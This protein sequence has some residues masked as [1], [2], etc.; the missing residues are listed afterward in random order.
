MLSEI[1]ARQTTSFEDTQNEYIVKAIAYI[2]ENISQ[3]LTIEQ[4]AAHCNMS[5]SSLSHLFKREMRIPLHRF[6]L[7]KRLMKAHHKIA[8]G[9]AATIAAADCGF[10]DYSG[11]YKQFKKMFGYAPSKRE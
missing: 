3:K 1:Q 7:K 5:V 11:F 9:E 4:I 2:N 8:E 6:I 10:C